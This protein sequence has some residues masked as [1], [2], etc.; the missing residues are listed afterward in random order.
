MDILRFTQRTFNS[1]KFNVEI[2]FECSNK[3]RQIAN[4]TFSFQLTEQE[5]ENI[6]WYL[7]DYLKNP[8]DPAPKIAAR[9]EK[10]LAE[11]G[12]NLFRSVF[13][14]NED[15][16]DLWATIR[17]NLNNIR[18]EISAEVEE[19]TSIPWELIRDPKT[20]TPIALRARAFVR[21]QP[22]TAQLPYIPEINI[23]TIR[24]L[25]IIC[26]PGGSDD[27]P[28]R[29]VASRLIKGLTSDGSSMF[30]LDVLRPPTFEQLG[31]VLRKA[32]S[33]GEPYHIV[34]FDGHG[35]FLNMEKFFSKWDKKT[36]EEKLSLL[37]NITNTS[38][39]QFSPQSIYPRTLPSGKHGYL[40]FENPKNKYN[41]RFVDGQELAKLLVETNVSMILL[42]ACRSAH[43][44]PPLKPENT[45]KE[46]NFHSQVRAIGSLAQELM[47]GGVAG[48]VA[49]RYNV[50]VVTAAQLVGHI[51]E[52]L[53]L[54][55]T[56]GEAV[57]EGRKKLADDPLRDVAYAPRSLQDW[58]VP[59]VY[60]A[61]P[62][63]FF[64]NS[65]PKEIYISVT[66][67]QTSPLR[68]SLD[69]KLPLSPD[70]GFFGRDETLLALDRAFDAQYI[71]L[72]HAYAGSGKTAT[73]AEF[74]RWY[75]LTGGVEGPVIFTSFQQYKPLS[76]LLNQLAQVFQSLLTQSNIQWL[77]LNDQERRQIA[78]QILK[79]VPVLWIWDN[80]E[81]VKGFP[82]NT[83]S[84]W[85]IDEQQDLASFLRETRD[86]RVKF[87]LT[88]RRDESTW[89]GDLPMRVAVPPMHMQDRFQMTKAL[90][91]KYGRI[92]SDIDNWRPLL[93][94]TRGNP[95]TITV[96]VS[97]ALRDKLKTRK[98]IEVF[99]DQLRNGETEFEDEE[100]EGRAQSLGASLNYGFVQSF[101]TIEQKQLALLHFFQCTVDLQ[102]FMLLGVSKLERFIPELSDL[103]IEAT[104]NL[105]DR[106]AEV[107]LLTKV[108]NVLYNIHPALPWF[109]KKLFDKYYR[110][111]S[112]NATHA[113]VNVISISGSY[114]ADQFSEGGLEMI[115]FLEAQESNLLYAY[116][117]A[118]KNNWSNYVIEIFE[119]INRLYTHM[120]RD[121][122][123]VRLF[124]ETIADFIDLPS[125]DP[126]PGKEEWWEIITIKRAQYAANLR[127][128]EKVE[129]LYSILENEYRRRISLFSTKSPEAFNDSEK[130][131]IEDLAFMLFQFGQ[132]QRELLD[133]KSF[134]TLTEAFELFIK[135]E[136][137]DLAARCGFQLG[138]AYF[139]IPSN[140]SIN[141]A[142]YWYE[143]L[144]EHF[145]GRNAF[146]EGRALHELGQV[147]YYRFRE[148]ITNKK[149]RA[150]INLL[151]NTALKHS[152]NALNLIP[153]NSKKELALIY[154]LLGNINDDAGYPEEAFS[155]Y[156]KAIHIYDI[157]ENQPGAALMRREVARSMLKVGRIDD[158]L[159]YAQAALKNLESLGA[160]AIEDIRRTQQ[161]IDGIKHYKKSKGE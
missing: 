43:A 144:L 56:L 15:A 126:L 27:V 40:S 143:R 73:A 17:T 116:E 32:K 58:S 60:E 148:A 67:G 103:S 65:N 48:V 141:K 124:N 19:A 101:T 36:D 71:V 52:M 97:Q 74:A 137:D 123:I 49:M 135:V 154:H 83:D 93:Q 149:P 133:S 98:Q 134:V 161:L 66:E 3:P 118:R 108:G 1:Q 51:Y 13:Q 10:S 12:I 2:A 28:F 119:S 72:L 145:K 20:D 44:E 59:I 109:F 94:F 63:S 18:V 14:S 139:D 25:L 89:L 46:T 6:R 142:E 153:P 30:Q 5:Q 107:G 41:L 159:L 7:E 70:V 158:A 117:L 33:A 45:D 79:N 91:H 128:T 35:A 8:Y 62:L 92:L 120:G 140:K 95:L 31:H 39:H 53:I 86:T 78:L 150:E 88:S 26:R 106:A 132:Y 80:V 160:G 21:T 9:I 152:Y 42:N 50:Y 85:N 104:T 47:H 81:L 76:H 64:T 38:T 75:T 100:S 61:S 130:K 125:D 29:S 55:K 136:N 84:A 54:G 151:L 155:N 157:Q 114:F 11:I 24:I 34:H 16:R 68:E 96:L 57:T 4:S 113:F 23:A 112:K 138:H 121:V 115:H 102:I 146:W 156:N 110:D 77:A 22:Q 69:P 122:E 87:L 90:A 99:V 131:M 82:E 127:N 37:N 129:H 147:N 105:L 111:S